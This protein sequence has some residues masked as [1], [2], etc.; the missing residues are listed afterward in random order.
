MVLEILQVLPPLTNKLILMSTLYECM[1]TEICKN[2]L[3][4]SLLT[5]GSG[6]AAL[7]ILICMREITVYFKKVI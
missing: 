1:T 2:I 3:I 7:L 5:N 4:E 6:R